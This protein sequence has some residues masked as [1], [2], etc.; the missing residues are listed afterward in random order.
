MAELEPAGGRVELGRLVL[1]TSNLVGDADLVATSRGGG[2]TRDG[3]TRGPSAP[4]TP[5]EAGLTEVRRPDGSPMVQATDV[6]EIRASQLRQPERRRGR[7]VDDGTAMR[8]EVPVPPP[9]HEQ[10]VLSV[11]EHG[12]TT[13]S[14]APR[15]ARGGATRDGGARTFVVPRP[16][17]A[18]GPEGAGGPDRGPGGAIVRQVLKV[19]TFPIGVAAGK[20]ANSFL[21]QWEE[22]HLRYGVR[23][24]LPDTYTGAAP[25]FDG[26]PA[27]W[28]QLSK[29]R[30]L[31]MVHG[32]F[33][34]AQGAF[35]ALPAQRM[36]ELNRM[37][38]GRVIAFDHHTI[39]DSPKE[40][41]ERLVSIIPAGTSLDVDI[42]CHSRGGLVARSLTE[43]E[44]DFPGNRDI[45]V[46]R[47]ALVGT[48]NNGTILADVEHWNDLIDML[49]TLINTVGIGI[50]EPFSLVL[51]FAQ[52]IAEAGYPQLRGLHSM[53]PGGPFL[54]DLNRRTPRLSNY[55]AIASN[56]EPTDRNLRA[57]LNDAIKDLI[58]E[59]NENDAMVRVDSVIGTNGKDEFKKVADTEL[60]DAKQ[61]IEHSQ[62]F[63]NDA[64][65]RRITSWLEAGLA[66]PA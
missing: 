24:Y 1:Q 4:E 27:R 36:A 31:L 49:S 59:D 47:T 45:R 2:G 12:V 16:P 57:F 62:Y 43:W 54:K 53:V 17:A 19:V 48:V 33:S 29:G 65:G 8:L 37:Y 11:N 46:H 15:A 61:G 34:R 7:S 32:T 28:T 52:D 18:P 35:G 44:G 10:A 22:Q 60:L 64:V 41:I 56:Y 38:E 9:D 20:V 55:L 63:G 51:S 26:D 14:F 40:N 6:V 23:D 13:W 30:T 25:Y 42:V 50:P 39:S 58:F 21:E 66:V 5:L 3:V